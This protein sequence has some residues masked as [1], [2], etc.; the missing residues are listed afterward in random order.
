MKAHNFTAAE[1]VLRTLVA[2]IDAHSYDNDNNHNENDDNA[3][4]DDED[5]P[6][7]DCLYN[8]AECLYQRE[9]YPEAVHYFKLALTYNQNDA[10]SNFKYGKL[11]RQFGRLEEAKLHLAKSVSVSRYEEA[12]YVFEYGLVLEALDD[13][14]NARQQFEKAYYLQPSTLKYK[15]TQI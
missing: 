14:H 7:F 10:D 3:D 13:E 4:Y 9:H 2:W 8:F 1:D 6:Y 11:L 12:D 5:I 15:L